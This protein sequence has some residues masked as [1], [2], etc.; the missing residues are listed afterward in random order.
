SLTFPINFEGNPAQDLTNSNQNY[1]TEWKAAIGS[2]R[3]YYIKDE[4]NRVN[5]PE[6]NYFVWLPAVNDCYAS[7]DNIGTMLHLEH[8]VEY[9]LCFS[10]APWSKNLDANGYPASGSATQKDGGIK[11][12]FKTQNG[13]WIE[14]TSWS[15]PK[16]SS[17]LNL[18][19]KQYSTTFIYDSSDPITQIYFTNSTSNSGVAVDGVTLRKK[20]CNAGHNWS[21]DCNDGRKVDLYG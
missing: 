4:V 3:M 15:L 21:F 20:D 17:W 12:E 14:T 16:S 18:N 7:S 8:G 13:N 11:M 19:W 2:P 5:N 6:G 1:I 10:A 9:V